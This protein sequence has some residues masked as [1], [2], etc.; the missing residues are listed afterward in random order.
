VEEIYCMFFG[1]FLN[2]L[3]NAS[4][5]NASNTT[6]IYTENT[7]DFVCHGLLPVLVALASL[8]TIRSMSAT[9]TTAN[10]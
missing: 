4:R 7:D 2:S 1:P 10:H 9:F 8:L 5:D 6:T 3:K